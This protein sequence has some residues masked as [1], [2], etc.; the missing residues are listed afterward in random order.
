MIS[1]I[2]ENITEKVVELAKQAGKAILEVYET[3]FEVETKIEGDYE[4][5]LTKADLASNKI[6]TEGLK[7]LTP[8]IPI[9]SEEE[10]T[11]SYDIRK[12]WSFVWIVDPLDGTKEFVKKNGEFT[13]SIAL[14]ANQLPV[15]GVIHIPVEGVTYY[16][17][18]GKGAFKLSD[19]EEKMQTSKFNPENVRITVTRS[20]LNEDTEKYIE[21]FKNKSLLRCGSSYKLC[22]VAEG[23]AD[24]CPRVNPYS[25]ENAAAGQIIVEEAGGEIRDVKGKPLKYNTEDLMI[26]SIIAVG[27]SKC[28]DYM[29]KVMK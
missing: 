23:S 18:A 10:E 17:E 7:K 22:K 4:S 16:A 25:E 24:I 20:H 29:K 1:K 26:S 19:K 14:I 3:D 12:N 9:I 28:F 21:K 6:I 5:P 11:P 27:D 13:V 8:E 15:I 2:D